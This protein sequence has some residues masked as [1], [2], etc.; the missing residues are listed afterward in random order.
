[1]SE[2][3]E[4]CSN[5]MLC[6]KYK[7]LV[8]LKNSKEKLWKTSHCCIANAFGKDAFVMKVSGNGM[9]EMFTPRIEG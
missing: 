1:M 2:N 3:Y 8:T 4:K 6:R 5:C 7:E 9:C